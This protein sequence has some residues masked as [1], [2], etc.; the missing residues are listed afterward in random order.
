MDT[1]AWG[2]QLWHS[3][4][5]IALGFPKTPT[6]SDQQHYKTFY[7]SMQFVLPCSV[8]TSHLQANLKRLP[9]DGSLTNNMTLFAW[10]VA[11][12]NM[13][14]ASLDKPIWSVEKAYDYYQNNQCNRPL[15]NVVMLIILALA[16]VAVF[17]IFMWKKPTRASNK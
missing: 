7:N 5:M 8:C 15:T 17:L 3:I 14:N 11:L 16:I 4:H 2:K 13:V 1:T 12:H 6:V 9:I 10:T